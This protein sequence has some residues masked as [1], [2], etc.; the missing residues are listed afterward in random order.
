[1]QYF[2]TEEERKQRHTTDCF[3]F[4]KGVH[5]HHWLEDSLCMEEDLFRELGLSRFFKE[6][7]QQFD[8]FGVTEV[9][10]EDWEELLEHAYERGGDIAKVFEELEP[11]AE[12]CFEEQDVF[13]ICGI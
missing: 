2:W 11:W 12:E 5:A 10:Y 8:Y 3:E 9:T 6:H 13:S 1:M 7:L 4:Q